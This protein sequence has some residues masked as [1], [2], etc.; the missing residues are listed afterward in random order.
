[1][2]QFGRWGRFGNQLFQYAFLKAYAERYGCELQLPPWVGTQLFGLSDP[3]ILA[4]LPPQLEQTNHLD[5]AE[6]PKGGEY[7]NRDFRGYAQYH[8]SFYKPYQDGMRRLFT[9]ITP[10]R[11]RLDPAVKTL[12]GT[13]EDDR[14][15]IGIHLRRG[16]YG[17]LIFYI[18]PVEWYLKWLDEHWGQFHNPVLFVATETPSLVEEF[19]AYSPVTATDLGIELRS[20]E[21]AHYPYLDADRL[22]REPWQL[23]FYPDFYLLSRCD[24]LVAPTST[25]S[26]MAA[27]L[28]PHLAEFWR[29]DL[30][31][32]RFVKEDVWSCFPIQHD[33]VDDY[34]VPGTYLDTNPPYWNRR[35]RKDGTY[36]NEI[37][38]RA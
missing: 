8:T 20:V 33:H 1:M 11:D 6:P 9:P 22:L 28:N 7:V 4:Q 16:D 19:A 12:Q 27:M 21:L 25:F 15:V 26:M 36:V 13:D 17:Q 29:S 31:E 23:D 38:V 37:R 14:T 2:S 34:M 35:I 5:Q 30:K 3:P 18:T 24:F 10:V 32:Q